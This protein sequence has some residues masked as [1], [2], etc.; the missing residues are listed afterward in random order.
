MNI[1]S[2]IKQNKKIQINAYSIHEN[3]LKNI[4]TVLKGILDHFNCGEL[5]SP[6]YTC[7][8]ELLVNAIKANFKH[9]YFEGYSSFANP[10]NPISYQMG[11]KLFKLEM[12]RENAAY[13]S[14]IAREEG[15]KAVV[16][17]SLE[18]RNLT[19]TIQNPVPMTEIEQDNVS[20]KLADARMCEDISDY[21]LKIEDDPNQE[22]AGLG[23]VLISIMLKNM[24]VPEDQFML[25]SNKNE[26]TASFCIPLTE[27]TREL[28]NSK[29]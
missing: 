8:K 2:I 4:E 26:T 12:S 27:D 5:Y 20:R 3:V 23:L 1:G 22:G 21:F 10:D 16:T 15:K 6:V 29:L 19:L 28:Y 11:L 17:F 9:I 24:G 25:Y 14:R 13:L 18:N 7:L